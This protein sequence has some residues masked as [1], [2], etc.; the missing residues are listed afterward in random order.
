MPVTRLTSM[1]SV[2]A[3]RPDGNAVYCYTP[4][5]VVHLRRPHPKDMEVLCNWINQAIPLISVLKV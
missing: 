1:K 5:T 4:L 3:R 2:P